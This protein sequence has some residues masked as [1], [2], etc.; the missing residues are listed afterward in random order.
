M[1]PAAASA[2]SPHLLTVR[3][4]R[5]L[6]NELDALR[7]DGWD[8][9][10]A[11]S[12]R[13][14]FDDESVH[15]VVSEQDRAVGMI[16]VTL[17]DRSVLGTWSNGQAP[18]PHG[19]DVAELTRGVVVESMRRH[20]IYRLAMLETVLSLR[21]LGAGAATAAIEPDFPGWPFLRQLGFL[22]VGA[23]VVFDD[24]P[25]SRTLAQ[26]IVLGIDPGSTGRWEDMRGI[27]LERLL[28]A[29]YA[30]QSGRRATSPPGKRQ[31]ALA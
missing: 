7:R 27:Q 11:L 26:P 5:R 19:A 4:E 12:A 14:E 25:R 31:P 17:S 10:S 13:D 9:C 30:V 15:V 28:A 8:A 22:A 20:G 18:L 1:R 29:G 21:G 3:L 23:P 6:T 24:F 16:R 2:I